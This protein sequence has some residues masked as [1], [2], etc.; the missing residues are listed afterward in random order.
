ME[1]Y[2]PVITVIFGLLGFVGFIISLICVALVAGFTR[3]THQVQYV[4]AETI[5][6][7]LEEFL[8][9][10]T[11]SYDL[12]ELEKAGKKRTEVL[13]KPID[14]TLEEISSSEISIG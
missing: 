10:P 14:E 7:E 11:A 5:N 2:I 6:P 1:Q 8:K 3:S 9:D 4:P 12:E 13:I